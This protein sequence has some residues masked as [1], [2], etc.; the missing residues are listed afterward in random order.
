MLV[1]LS[2]AGLVSGGA[3]ARPLISPARFRFWIDYQAFSSPE[4]AALPEEALTALGGVKTGEPGQLTSPR[5]PVLTGCAGWYISG[6]KT[7]E[8]SQQ[9]LGC[10]QQCSIRSWL[11]LCCTPVQ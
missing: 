1:C 5:L 4:S 11:L 7:G 6:L 2:C 9:R 8:Q 10:Q 3:V